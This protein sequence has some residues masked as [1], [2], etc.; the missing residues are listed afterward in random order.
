MTKPFT[1]QQAQYLKVIISDQINMYEQAV[2]NSKSYI[3]YLYDHCDKDKP[4]ETFK[5]FKDMNSQK[6]AVRYF[7]DE[8]KKLA[9][10]QKVVKQLA[11]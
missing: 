3:T 7:K 10:I 2:K 6:I 11:K 4:E 9:A 1:T 5:A 8:I